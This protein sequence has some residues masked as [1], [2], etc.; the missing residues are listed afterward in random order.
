MKPLPRRIIAL[1]ERS[2]SLFVSNLHE[3]ISSTELEAMFYRAG[4]IVDTFIPKDRSTGKGRDFAF[5]RFGTR[6]EAEIA[7][8][9]AKGRSWKGRKV[10]AT[11]SNPVNKDVVSQQ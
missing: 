10:N 9:L 3:A 4:K 8:E 7:V 11:I 5:V 6:R 2:V 1:R